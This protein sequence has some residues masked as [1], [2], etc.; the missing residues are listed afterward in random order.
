M[1]TTHRYELSVE[2]L[3]NRG[4]GT[5]GYRDFDRTHEVRAAG[6]PPIAASADPAVRGE[7]ER[8]NPEELLVAALAQCHMLW[9]LHL[10]S[11]GGVIVTHYT[12]DPVATLVMDG[13]GG[14]G[15]FSEV[16]L[17]PVVTV[18]DAAMSDKARALHGDI[19]AKCFI[20]RSVN[21]PVRHEPSVQV[22]PG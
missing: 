13:K 11:V 5:S 8:W 20:A 14:G 3:G 9:Y 4:S 7:V 15:Q 22:N 2:W 19:G 21:F 10:A 6:K 18:T 12:D 16:T 17:R 1:Q